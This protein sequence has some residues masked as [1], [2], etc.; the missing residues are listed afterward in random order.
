MPLYDYRCTACGDRFEVMHG[1]HAPGPESCPACGSGPV[2]KAL[3]AP[4]IVFKGS[5]WAK[6]D[7]R[8]SASTR[9]GGDA[10]KDSGG[11]GTDTTR[12]GK[13][14]GTGS[15]ASGDGGSAAGSGASSGSGSA[16]NAS[17]GGD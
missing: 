12:D 4:A 8:A 10:G 11:T 17:G 3:A 9:G 2:V 15:P 14:G 6:I 5:G 1:V 7:R 16:G 13:A